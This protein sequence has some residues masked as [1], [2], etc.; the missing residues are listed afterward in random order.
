MD[1]DWLD[2]KSKWQD[3]TMIDVVESE[4]HEGESKSLARRYFISS[5]ATNAEHFMYA[6]RS[7]WSVE[8]NLHWVLDIGFRED[9]N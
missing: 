2:Q 7:H 5:L 9:E 3:L 4:R 8:N 6:V 1:I